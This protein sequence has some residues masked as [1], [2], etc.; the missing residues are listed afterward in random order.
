[1]TTTA[2]E[3]AK[4]TNEELVGVIAKIIAVF[5]PKSTN[6]WAVEIFDLASKEL[7]SRK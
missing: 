5:G 6:P 7:A 2:Q 4:M 1:M 3:L